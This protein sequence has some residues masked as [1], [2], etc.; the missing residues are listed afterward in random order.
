[1][2]MAITENSMTAPG[3]LEGDVSI[4]LLPE[5]V[6]KFDPGAESFPK[7]SKVFLTHLL[8]KDPQVQVDAA[9]RLL[10]HGYVP[11]VHLGAR[12][13]KSEKDYVELLKA[14]SQNGVSHG[15]FLGGNPL[16]SGGPFFEALDLL[17]HSVLADTTFS[18]AFI[19]GYPEGH[20]DIET[21]VLES[22][23]RL[24]LDTCRARGLSPE[25]VSQFAFDGKLMATWAS[26]FAAEEPEVPIRLGFAGVTSLP[27]LIKFAVM[28][29]V[30]PSVAALKKNA[31]G[32][33]KVMNDRD[34]GDV[35]DQVDNSYFGPS[36]LNA[37]FFP[38]GGWQ[39]TIKWLANRR[40]G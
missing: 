35:I 10:S 31:G 29:G 6:A 17:E 39:K 26:K 14:H 18:H 16:R 33:L 15:L 3:L 30:G 19:G 7:G 38:F 11:V 34:P 22:A 28:C 9:R 25:L 4:E 23:I 21:S 40:A 20:P 37:H 32:F 36:Q 12:N 1:M 2:D 8:G 5:M 24:K 27:K 13:F